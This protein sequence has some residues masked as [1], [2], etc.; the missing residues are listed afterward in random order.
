MSKSSSFLTVTAFALV[1]ALATVAARASEATQ[2]VDPPGTYTR[3]Q[4]KQDLAASK[5]D[6][7]VIHYGDAT[8]FVDQPSTV[9]RAEVLAE[10][11]IWKRSALAQLES[12]DITDV[13]SNQYRRAQARY[14]ALRASPQFAELVQSIARKRGD[15]V[16][17]SEPYG[18]ELQ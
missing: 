5:F 14:A 3:A 7:S 16:M 4:V 8:A 10:V 12:G 15:T 6:R 18:S 1:S 2:F 9:S 11:E 17:A 13:F